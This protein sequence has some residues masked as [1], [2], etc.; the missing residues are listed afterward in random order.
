MDKHDENVPQLKRQARVCVVR[1]PVLETVS[2]VEIDEQVDE[3]ALFLDR[4]Y[5]S[6]METGPQYL[7]LVSEILSIIKN[8]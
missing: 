3:I 6:N 1:R 7:R 5:R 4:Q 2:D 8:K